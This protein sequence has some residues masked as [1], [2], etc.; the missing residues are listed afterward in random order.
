MGRIVDI[1]EAESQLSRLIDQVLAGEEV[2]ISREDEPVAVLGPYIGDQRPRELGGWAGRVWIAD[3]FDA[4]LPQGEL[5]P[6]A[7]PHDVPLDRLKVAC[8]SDDTRQVGATERGRRAR[9]GAVEPPDP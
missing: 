4:P 2:I 8:D 3:D 6:D 7:D 1:S 5:L 9:A